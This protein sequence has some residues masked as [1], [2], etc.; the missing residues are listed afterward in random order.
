MPVR[1]VDIHRAANFPPP[2]TGFFHEAAYSDREIEV[3]D[4]TFDELRGTAS[5]A[6]KMLR[7]KLAAQERLRQHRDH[8]EEEV[9]EKAD[10]AKS[11]FLAN[12]SHELRTPLNAVLGFSQLLKNA[13]G[14]TIEQR[15]NLGGCPR[16]QKS[17]N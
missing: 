8:L 9:A 6:N 5:N 14:V 15:K 12:M 1:Q 17:K 10:R 7:D 4:V 2:A 13:P 3:A 11:V 16:I